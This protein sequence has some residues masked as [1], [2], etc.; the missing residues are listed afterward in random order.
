MDQYELIRTAHRVYKKSIRQIARETGHTRRTIRKVLAGQEPRYRQDFLSEGQNLFLAPGRN[1]RSALW[2]PRFFD[3]SPGFR[4]HHHC[5]NLQGALANRALFQGPQAE[6]TGQDLRRQEP[7][8]PVMDGVNGNRTLHAFLTI[9]SG[10][11]VRVRTTG[12]RVGTGRRDGRGRSD[13]RRAPTHRSQGAER[14]EAGTNASI[15][16]HVPISPRHRPG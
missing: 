6:S 3:E 11:E 9:R 12:P 5:R 1:P 2:P 13:R 4:S 15:G 7:A 14:P 16:S 8:C 10:A